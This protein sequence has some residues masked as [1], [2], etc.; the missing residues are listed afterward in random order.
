M[1][2]NKK[3]WKNGDIITKESLNNIEDGIY[4]AHDEIE[5][6]KN[7]TSTGGSSGEVDLSRYVTKETGNASQITFSD[8]QT[9]QAKLDAGTLKGDKGDPGE[10]GTS[11]I[12][13]ATASTTTTYSSSKIESIKQELSSQIGGTSGGTSGGPIISVTDFGAVGDGVANDTQAFKDALASKQD[14]YVPKGTYL[15]TDKLLVRTFQTLELSRYALLKFSD[16]PVCIEIG[17]NGKLKGGSIFVNR[18]FDGIVIDMSNANDVTLRDESYPYTDGTNTSMNRHRRYL[19]EVYIQRQD[20]KPAASTDVKGVAVRVI[21]S[22]AIQ[23]DYT[24]QWGVNIDKVN[25]NGGFESGI[26]VKTEYTQ[27]GTQPWLHD[28]MIKDTFMQYTKTAIR[29]DTVNNVEILGGSFQ[30]DT[31]RNGEKY[32]ICGVKMNN[33]NT[34]HIKGFTVWDTHDFVEGTTSHAFALTGLCTGVE[35]YD[36][37][38]AFVNNAFSRIYYD[39]FRTLLTLRYYNKAGR[40]Y[41]DEVVNYKSTQV[42]SGDFVK[43]KVSNFD[44]MAKIDFAIGYDERNKT[45]ATSTNPLYTKIGTIDLPRSASDTIYQ[46]TI[47]ESSMYGVIGYSTIAFR[48]DANGNPTVRRIPRLFNNI[49]TDLLTKYAYEKTIGDETTTIT[50]LRKFTNPRQG[51]HSYISNLRVINAYLF[52]TKINTSY[53]PTSPIDV[54]EDLQLYEGYCQFSKALGKPV[55]WDGSRWIDSDGKSVS[56]GEALPVGVNLY[57]GVLTDGTLVGSTGAEYGNDGRQRT[58]FIAINGTKATAQMFTPCTY[59]GIFAYDSGKNFI[60][61]ESTSS[62]KVTVEDSNLAYVRVVFNKSETTDA[63]IQI[64]KGSGSDTYIPP[65]SN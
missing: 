46:V 31:T 40:V 60:K 45:Q 23:Q 20:S 21:A 2:Y 4:T 47:Q 38:D 13:D 54:D 16:I 48:T 63:Q 14:I 56:T 50:L 51:S 18:T 10:P 65:I 35:I 34:V 26:D 43:T 30:P 57:N 15:I 64:E 61:Y 1:S 32:I 49:D 39:N 53:T 6:L 3:I 29:L 17:M 55:W 33:C 22:D 12:D 62:N 24:C 7:N 11:N 25:I 28:T 42:G 5:R 37:V 27:G 36:F 19:E 52:K 8:G 58:G 41:F 44:E 9:F 59:I